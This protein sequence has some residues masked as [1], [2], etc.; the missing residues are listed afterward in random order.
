[1]ILATILATILGIGDWLTVAEFQAICAVMSNLIGRKTFTV[2]WAYCDP[3][4]FVFIARIFEFFDWGSWSLFETALGVKPHDLAAVYGVVGIPLVGS[5]ARFLSSTRF[6]DEVEMTSQISEFR[7][8]SFD[9]EHRLI[10]RGETTVEGR[11]TRVWAGRD[12]ADPD[13]MKSQ[14]IPPEV[15]AR[16]R[17][18]A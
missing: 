9:V 10:V 7:R 3:A 12:P 1:M 6:G 16:F 15:T 11:E 18:S 2:K 13:K 14:P 5:G 4:G 8:S 17:V